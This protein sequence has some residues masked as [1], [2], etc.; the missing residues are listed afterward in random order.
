MLSLIFLMTVCNEVNIP[1]IPL[2]ESQVIKG[3]TWDEN[4][5]RLT[6]HR[7]GDNWPIT[8]CDD[9]LQITV[10]GDGDGFDS[11]NP[12]LSLGFSRITGDPPDVRGEDFVSDADTPVGWGPK[13]IK[14]SGLLMADDILYM[15]VRN[16]IPPGSEDFTNSHL[17]WSSDY[18]E[19]W[20]WAD[21]YFQDTFG[22]PEF[23]Q[24]GKNYSGTRDG[25]VYLVSQ[26]NDNAY[27]YSPD[28]VLARVP[29]DIIQVREEY[30]F[31]AGFTNDGQPV[32][33]ADIKMRKPVFHDPNGTQRIAVTY[34]AGLKRYILTT[35][36][37]PP[38]DDRTHSDALGIFD[39][40]EPWGPWTTVYY[41]HDWSNDCRTYHHKFPTKW[42]SRDGKTMW[43]L[44]SGLD[45]DLYTI[46]LQKVT[47]D[48][49]LP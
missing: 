49:V 8:W 25:F 34:N 5:V 1:D 2:P 14:T 3:I 48:A 32:W 6:S 41:N 43:L 36:H 18:G 33:D 44:F 22:C 19:H 45:C 4:I 40:P 27:E 7:I 11:L 21:W 13:G 35:S 17:G 37:R 9:N 16:Y 31:F 15:F 39:A 10:Y 29:K 23:V 20:T 26:D 24:F 12:D 38:G 28:I 47:L 30:E 46:C 42:M